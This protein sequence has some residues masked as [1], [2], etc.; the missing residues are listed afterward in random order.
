MAEQLKLHFTQ[1]EIGEIVPYKS[2]FGFN[3]AVKPY[4]GQT[5]STNLP[6]WN[7]YEG[8]KFDGSYKI[9]DHHDVAHL[10]KSLESKSVELGFAVHV[11]DKKEAMI[12]FLSIGGRAGTVLDIPGLFLPDLSCMIVKKSI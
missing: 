9:R 5:G 11:N 8:M 6:I 10:M 12:Q 3:S 7:T 1:T 2:V 4:D